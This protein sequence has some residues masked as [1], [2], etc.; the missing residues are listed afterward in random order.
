[1]KKFQR[2]QEIINILNS[3]KHVEVKKLSK[4]FNVTEETIRRDL[5]HLE[6]QIYKKIEHLVKA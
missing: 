6:E 1:M 3:Y 4:S 5:E 2:Y